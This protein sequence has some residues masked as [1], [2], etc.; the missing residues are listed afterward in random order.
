MFRRVLWSRTRRE[1]D[2]GQ[3]DEDSMSKNEVDKGRLVRGC[4]GFECRFRKRGREVAGDNSNLQCSVGMHSGLRLRLAAGPI[5][6]YID[7]V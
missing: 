7:P 3:R 4:G 6:P 2:D 1:K 5:D